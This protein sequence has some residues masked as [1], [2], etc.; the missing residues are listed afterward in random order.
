MAGLETV[1]VD[2]HDLHR[3][4]GGHQSDDSLESAVDRVSRGQPTA[5]TM[6]LESQTAVR[7]RRRRRTSNVQRIA[8]HALMLGR[9]RH[10]E[11]RRPGVAIDDDLP[12]DRVPGRVREHDRDH[13][14]SD[15][16][17]GLNREA[18]SG[19]H[20]RLDARHPN[21]R[22]RD[23]LST[24][25][26]DN[27]ARADALALNRC[28]NDKT[29]TARR[30][31]HVDDALVDLA[32]A[33]VIQSVA[34]LGR[35]GMPRRIGVVAVQRLD[36]AVAIGVVVADITQA[37][38]IQIRLSCVGSHRAVVAMI[39]P[40]VGVGVEL[41]SVGQ[42]RTV[43]GRVVQCVVVPVIV[44]AIA[45]AVPVAIL[46]FERWIGRTQIADISPAVAVGIRLI[47]IRPPPAVIR[48]K[49]DPVVVPV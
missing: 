44:A 25:V 43:V 14:L 39:A 24:T 32:V 40:A 6:D 33:V 26:H 9:V 16:H 15:R 22:P 3:G 29:Q 47:G 49:R 7:R 1:I 10:R 11:C 41:V 13:A 21:R 35:P 12:R 4:V 2:G 20:R 36:R 30:T 18:A 17:R 5:N 28:L 34:T 48:G 37:I 46:V 42:Q 31:R 38:G 27:C 8:D 45:D 19:A 23:R